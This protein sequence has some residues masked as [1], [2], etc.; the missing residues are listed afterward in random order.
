L[1]PLTLTLSQPGEGIF[2]RM[3]D[4]DASLWQESKAPKLDDYT[5]A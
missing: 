5:G 4:G 3:M 2:E 1:I